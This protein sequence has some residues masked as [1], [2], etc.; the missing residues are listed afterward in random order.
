MRL[1]IAK[2]ATMRVSSANLVEVD[3]AEDGR[4]HL[5]TA[6]GAGDLAEWAAHNR[7]RVE[8]LL[9][10]TGAVLF[11]GFPLAREAAFEAVVRTFSGDAPYLVQDQNTHNQFVTDHENVWYHN[12][13]CDRVAWPRYLVFWCEQTGA[14]GGQTPFADCARVY[15]DLPPHLRRRFETQGWVLQRR[16][17]PGIGVDAKGYFKT[18]DPAE[19][20]RQAR[21]LGAFDQRWSG[22]VLTGFSARFSPAVGHPVTGEQV[23]ANNLLFSNIA[24]VE[25]TI[26]DRLLGDYSPDELPVTT[27]WGD[28][29]PVSDRDIAELRDVYLANEVCFDW[30]QGDVLLLDNIRCAHGRRPILG[31]QRVN[32]GVC[33]F[34]TRLN[35]I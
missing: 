19:I 7:E 25:E 15:R 5:V 24:M 2:A 28:G 17:H 16:F 13:Y 23:W 20:R 3:T 33:D 9:R 32:V 10:R 1:Q 8:E 18:A 31:P 4:L 30:R 26:R 11:R 21:L 35:A 22:D 27:F 29:A 12:D 14:S 6:T 34:H